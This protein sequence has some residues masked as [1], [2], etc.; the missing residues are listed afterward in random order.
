MAKYEAHITCDIENAKHVENIGDAQGWKYSAI[1]GDALLGKKPYCYL[2]AYEPDA[3]HLM[4][5]MELAADYLVEG[6]VFVYRKKIER[7]IYDTKTGVDE[8][9]G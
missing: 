7:I 6:G 4:D 1:H 9:N 2:T 8:I 5:R 3:K